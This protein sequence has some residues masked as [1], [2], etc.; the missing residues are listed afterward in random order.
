MLPFPPFPHP[1]TEFPPP[2]GHPIKASQ[3]VP[4]SWASGRPG[5][6]S[7]SISVSCCLH[8]CQV[9]SSHRQRCSPTQRYW[10]TRLRS[11]LD[12]LVSADVQ[13]Q[14]SLTPGE[15]AG[16]KTAA[17]SQGSLQ[18]KQLP[19][20]PEKEQQ[21]ANRPWPSIEGCLG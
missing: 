8:L 1:N 15:E 12:S 13:K 9:S 10:G 7:E 18:R 21:E 11:H 14:T 4:A 5:A 16:W 20:G 2:C 3:S 6:L 19:Q 17:T